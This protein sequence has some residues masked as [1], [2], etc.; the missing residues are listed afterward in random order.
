MLPKVVTGG[1]RSGRRPGMGKYQG[2]LLWGYIIRKG[3]V[4]FN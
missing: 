3:G 1:L 2:H 4:R